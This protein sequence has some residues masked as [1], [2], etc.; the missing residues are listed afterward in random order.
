MFIIITILGY[1]RWE[2]NEREGKEKYSSP[3]TLTYQVKSEDNFCLVSTVADINSATM[4]V[5][6]WFETE[7]G[8]GYRTCPFRS[9][10]IVKW[11]L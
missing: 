8:N 4:L 7:R 5:I 2:E 11:E 1:I 3:R 9:A 10:L 6:S